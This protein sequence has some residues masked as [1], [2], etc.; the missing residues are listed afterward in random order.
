MVVFLRVGGVLVAEAAAATFTAGVARDFASGE[1]AAYR[2]FA[3]AHPGLREKL[4]TPSANV[5][6]SAS[7]TRTVWS[8]R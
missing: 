4:E 2:L 7:T 6:A 1:I 8:E 3:P 5:A